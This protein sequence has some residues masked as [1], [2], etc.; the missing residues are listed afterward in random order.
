MLCFVLG[1]SSSFSRKLPG[2]LAYSQRAFIWFYYCCKLIVKCRT[3]NWSF[4]GNFKN[5]QAYPGS[6]FLTVPIWNEAKNVYC[7]TN[8]MHVQSFIS[9]HFTR[10]GIGTFSVSL[11]RNER[12]FILILKSRLR[13]LS[14]W[15]RYAETWKITE[16]WN[17]VSSQKY[18]FVRLHS[19]AANVKKSNVR[20]VDKCWC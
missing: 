4:S 18:Q 8:Q 10:F 12:Q 13:K 3:Q 20:C 9:L 16:I 17:M 2:F 6:N 19:E 1:S 15:Y 14:P 7:E 5:F 11:S